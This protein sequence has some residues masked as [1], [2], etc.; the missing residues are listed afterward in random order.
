MS[1]SQAMKNIATA[2]MHDHDADGDI[3]HVLFDQPRASWDPF[4][5]WLSRIKQPRDAAHPRIDLP[6]S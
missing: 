4:E 5:V 3:E 6:E 2:T 1:W